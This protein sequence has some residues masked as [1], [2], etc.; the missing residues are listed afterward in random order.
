MLEPR[1]KAGVLLTAPGNGGESLIE[2]AGPRQSAYDPIA[3]ASRSVS[4]LPTET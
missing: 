1:I 2:T 4:C 3:R